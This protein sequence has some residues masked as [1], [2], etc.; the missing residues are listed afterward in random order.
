MNADRIN[1]IAST[2]V[3]YLMTLPSGTAISTSDAVDR[4]LGCKFLT[5]GDYQI[6]GEP[7]DTMEFFD[8]DATVRRLAEK[9][10]LVLDSSAYAGAAVGLPFHI[11]YIISPTDA[12][13]EEIKR[14]H[15]INRK[16]CMSRSKASGAARKRRV[17]TIS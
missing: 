7:V 8:I 6:G 16:P 1:E 14:R 5:G 10:D 9:R 3:E 15:R 13:L 12:Q 17:S 4:I 11:P 2:I